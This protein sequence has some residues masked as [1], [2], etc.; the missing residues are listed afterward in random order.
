M[1]GFKI[2]VFTAEG[3]ELLNVAKL[4]LLV[5]RAPHCD[6][7]P[8]GKDVADEHLRIWS[9]GGHLWGQ[10]LGSAAGTNV[11]GQLLQPM[12][13]F[14]FHVKLTRLFWAN[15]GSVWRSRTAISGRAVRPRSASSDREAA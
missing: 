1:S 7:R 4:H 10:D 8:S 13:P 15:R 14:L 11:N 9:D 2:K 6:V 5:G 12:R 3:V